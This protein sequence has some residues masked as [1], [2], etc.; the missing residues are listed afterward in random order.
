VIVLGA[1]DIDI[2][3]LGYVPLRYVTDVMDCD[4]LVFEVC[5]K[6]LCTDEAPSGSDNVTRFI[7]SVHAR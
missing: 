6:R 3:V 7:F 5:S 2:L 1:G 4:L